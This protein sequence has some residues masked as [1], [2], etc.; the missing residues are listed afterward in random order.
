MVLSNPTDQVL[1]ITF[2]GIDYEIEAESTLDVDDAVGKHWL[3]IHEF[4][5]VEASAP[6]VTEE[7]K[8]TTKKDK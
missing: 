1:K 7:K 3:K 8:S 6:K 4:L 2:K 5:T